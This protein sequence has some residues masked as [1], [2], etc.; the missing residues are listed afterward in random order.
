MCQSERL[1]LFLLES[2]IYFE[3]K[4]NGLDRDR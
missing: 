1:L 3:T 2:L 4:L